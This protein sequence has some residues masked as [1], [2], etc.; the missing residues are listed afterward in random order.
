[1]QLILLPKVLLPERQATI[2][3]HILNTALLLLLLII[4]NKSEAQSITIKVKNESLESVLKQIGKQAG[5]EV[6]Y[7]EDQLKNAPP[8][9]LNFVNTDLDKV[10]AFVLSGRPFTY[11]LVN[12]TIVIRAKAAPWQPG[13]GIKTS[14]INVHGIVVDDK[15]VPFSNLTVQV[16]GI[17]RFTI[18]NDKG[19]FNFTQIDA[20]SSL[21]IY[22]LNVNPVYLEINGRT[23]LQVLITEK[24]N[25]LQT[26]VI[27]KGYYTE[28]QR[29]TTGDVVT[30]KGTDILKTPTTNPILALEGRVP[31]LFVQ[32]N[33]G[34]PG[35]APTVTLRGLNSIS[36][37]NSPL[38]IVDGIPYNQNS[39]SLL[40]GFQNS[41]S[42]LPGFGLDPLSVLN[43]NDIESITVLK[44]AD[45]TSIYGSRGANGV[46]LITTK[47]GKAG[48]M[49]GTLNVS[50]AL[51]QYNNF[52][53]LLNTQQYL[54]VRREALQNDGLAP[55]S[56]T[57]YDIN[58]T[59][60][61]SRYTN[62]QKTL[63]GNTAHLDNYQGTLSGGDGNTQYSINGGYR[64]QSLIYTHSSDLGDK[65]ASF[66]ANLNHTS[67]NKKLNIVFDLAYI[68]DSNVVPVQDPTG[69]A[70]SLPPD[71]PNLYN[72]DGTLNFENGTFQNPLAGLLQTAKSVTDNLLG[73]MAINYKITSDLNF[74][75][76]TGYNKQQLDEVTLIPAASI[77][78]VYLAEDPGEVQA[79]QAHG[80]S[81]SWIFEPQLNYSHSFGKNKISALVGGTLQQT[82]NNSYGFTAIGAPNDNVLQD[83]SSATTITALHPTINDYN[84]EAVY[85]RLNYNWDSKYIINLTARRD[86]SS[87]FGPDNRFGN[88]GA[89]GAAWL[90][91][92][93]T[94]AKKLDW[95]SLGKLR[96]SYGITGND[97]ITNYSYFSYYTYNYNPYQGETTLSPSGLANPNVHWEIDKKLE[98]GLDLGF[99]SNRINFTANYFRNRTA[100]QLVTTTLPDISGITEVLENLPAVVQNTGFEGVVNTINVKTSAFIWRSAFNISTQQNKLISFPNIAQTAFANIYTVG[101]SLYSQ[102]RYHFTGVDPAT[103]LYTFEDVNKDG[104]LNQSDYVTSKPIAPKFYGG[105]NNSFSYKGFQLDVFFQFVKQT[106]RSYLAGSSPGSFGNQPAAVLQAWQAPG[107]NSSIQRFTSAGFSTAAGT[108]YSEFERSDGIIVDGSF[109]RLKNVN[110]SYSLPKAFAS[111]IGASAAQIYVTGDNLL[112]FTPYVGG[113]PEIGGESLPPLRTLLLGINLSF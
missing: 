24:I 67:L 16:V 40:G 36:N 53:T 25:T 89:A 95:L 62:W 92:E 8:V 106:Q 52:E 26:V 13:K 65:Q 102:K 109:I 31:G 22:G 93:E 14:Y 3:R 91:S 83:Y 34:L 104:T 21:H 68:N 15:G 12:K 78:P 113:D 41:G 98:F 85:A 79:D 111:K 107:D 44:D 10:L 27:D 47:K 43:P 48:N 19:E 87:R 97:Q 88:F 66:R 32:Q 23:E 39:L 5:Y 33:S 11:A 57:D 28:E 96:G 74:H 4:S 42:A 103:G 64:T 94:W 69:A 101:Q 61:Q 90:F 2:L 84:Y 70:L 80:I 86:G 54:A 76:N 73:N 108:S 56:Y 55:N 110:L 49:V 100:N 1:M 81:K 37:G 77:N 99:L 9:T 6:F 60:D 105:L 72:A 29:L 51:S 59:W 112:T 63:L 18:T 35:A 46:I 82:D 45:A 75:A 17:N 38:Y 7:R 50:S 30:V 58:G 71:A 20:N